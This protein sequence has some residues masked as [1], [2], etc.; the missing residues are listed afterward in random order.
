MQV[1]DRY[2]RRLRVER[3]QILKVRGEYN[4]TPGCLALHWRGDG[5][6]CIACRSARQSDSKVE[7]NVFSA[8][9]RLG[10]APTCPTSSTRRRGLCFLRRA[11]NRPF[12]GREKP[13]KFRSPLVTNHG[14]SPPARLVTP[15]LRH[16]KTGSSIP[17][18]I[19][20]WSTQSPRATKFNAR[21]T[22]SIR[23][24]FNLNQMRRLS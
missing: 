19:R 13:S 23:V 5:W 17:N 11:N 14:F 8:T 1:L 21:S 3:R 7:V 24:S 9:F 2:Q 16:Q 4:K 18:R 15:P 12:F 22:R 20:S 10:A 6:G